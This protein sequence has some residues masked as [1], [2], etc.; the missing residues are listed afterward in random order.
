MKYDRV[1]RTHGV[2]L[3]VCWCVCVKNTPTPVEEVISQRLSRGRGAWEH[4][5]SDSKPPRSETLVPERGLRN[6]LGCSL[7]SVELPPKPIETPNLTKLVQTP[8]KAVPQAIE[9]WRLLGIGMI[10]PQLDQFRVML[11]TACSMPAESGPISGEIRAGSTEVRP[12]RFPS[13][14]AH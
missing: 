5:L 13:Y 2:S 10:L 14:A 6:F 12:I 11:N 1:M 4:F 9:T 8:V 3:T 7:N